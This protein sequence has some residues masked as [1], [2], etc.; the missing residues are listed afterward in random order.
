[1]NTLSFIKIYPIQIKSVYPE[2]N[3]HFLV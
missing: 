3:K 1:M 2:S